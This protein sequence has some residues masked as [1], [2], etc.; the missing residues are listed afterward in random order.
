MNVRDYIADGVRAVRQ[1]FSL[2]QEV[3]LE[4]LDR[5]AGTAGTGLRVRW[6]APNIFEFFVDIHPELPAAGDPG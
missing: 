4:Q 2:N 6:D 1:L 5:V 3:F